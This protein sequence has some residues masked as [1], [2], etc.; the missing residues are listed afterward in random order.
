MIKDSEGGA[1]K[2]FNVGA[3][4]K[5]KNPQLNQVSSMQIDK[6]IGFAIEKALEFTMIKTHDTLNDFLQNN[7]TLGFY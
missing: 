4:R 6:D 1:I 7:P 5:F 3:W 2:V